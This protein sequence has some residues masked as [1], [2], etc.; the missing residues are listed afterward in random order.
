MKV[1]ARFEKYGL[2]GRWRLV[3]FKPR[4]NFHFYGAGKILEPLIL[5]AKIKYLKASG[6]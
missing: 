1:S 3:F 4:W 6:T 2:L 5:H